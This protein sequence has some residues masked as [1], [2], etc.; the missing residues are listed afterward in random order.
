MKIIV[1]DYD[2]LLAPRAS[3]NILQ[4]LG[5]VELF[6]AEA[7]ASRALADADAVLTVSGRLNADTIADAPKLQYIGVLGADCSCVDMAAAGRAGISVSALPDAYAL[8]QVQYALKAVFTAC[9]DPFRAVSELTV[10]VVGCGLA[11]RT[12]LEILSKLGARTLAHE[13][14]F[15]MSYHRGVIHYVLQA[16]RFLPECDL[17]AVFRPALPLPD[18][19]LTMRGVYGLTHLYNYLD[20]EKLSWMKDGA[21]LVDTYPGVVDKGAVTA[22][23]QNRKLGGYYDTMVPRDARTDA[24]LITQAFESLRKHVNGIGEYIW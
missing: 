18:A 3:W 19:P 21:I 20:T 12:F 9:A 16:D 15:N 17:V 22:A 23:V 6:A 7:D 14:A 13:H 24:Q 11:G 4:S 5:D 10:G 1:L 2:N 8:I